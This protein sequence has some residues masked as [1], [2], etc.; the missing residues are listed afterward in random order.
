M[1]AVCHHRVQSLRS[2]AL[3]LDIDEMRF[4]AID[5]STPCFEKHCVLWWDNGRG[6]TT[7]KVTLGVQVE[8]RI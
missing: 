5:S 3:G 6:K 7:R 4:D 1:N 8:N 2:L